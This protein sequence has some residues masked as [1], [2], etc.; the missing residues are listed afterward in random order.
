MMAT[1]NTNRSLWINFKKCFD[2]V[3][4]TCAF[5]VLF[6]MVLL[7]E[8]ISATYI[9]ST[10]QAIERQFQVPSKLSGVMVSASDFAYIPM[11]IFVSYFGSKGNRV[12]WIGIGTLITAFSHLLI[13]SSN[14]LFPVEQ[15][16][17][18]YSS[19][20]EDLLP[21]NELLTSNAKFSQ[22]FDYKLIK[23][24]V[25]ETLREKFLKKISLMNDNS[26]DI[27]PS[28]GVDYSLG[29]NKT[30]N[31]ADNYTLNERLLSEIVQKMHTVIGSNTNTSTI[32]EVRNLLQQYV[33]ERANEV[34]HDLDNIKNSA[35]APFAFCS[36]SINNMRDIINLRPIIILF[37]GLIGFGVGRCMPW[38]LGV[39]IIDDSFSKKN[40]PT[41]FGISIDQKMLYK[42]K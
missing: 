30:M 29:T 9:I 40:L 4:H 38:S 37:F 25:N 33:N 12:K 3:N 42:Y 14:F 22:F 24:R 20:H 32:R 19:F 41:F 7:V 36:K 31:M 39:P 26:F 28:R 18:N 23:D 13:S 2:N 10:T 11:V 27:M 17:L 34:M 6:A 1:E 5:F 15:Q 8:S 16:M 21:S 35:R